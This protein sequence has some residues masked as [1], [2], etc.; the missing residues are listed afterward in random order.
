M[1]EWFFAVPP[2][3]ASANERLQCAC[4]GQKGRTYASNRY[5]D[6]KHEM[7][8]LALRSL[9]GKPTPYP[10]GV[11]HVEIQTKAPRTHR[12]GVAVGLAFIDVDAPIKCVLDAISGVAYTDDSQV[13][14]VVA[15]KTTAG[16]VGIR[17]RVY[18]PEEGTSDDD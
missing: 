16:P 11:V 9:L 17:V 8:M 5:K 18:R 10:E 14:R 6:A 7:R 12:K 4:I 3:A 1:K 13:Q 15:T 2:S